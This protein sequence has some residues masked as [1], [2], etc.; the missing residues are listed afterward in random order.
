M[1]GRICQRDVDLAEADEPVR[2]AAERMH[3]RAVGSLV[4]VDEKQTPIGIVTDRDLTIRVLAA[5]RDADTTPVRDVMTSSP[6]TIRE[7]EPIE[8]AV[9]KM[10]QGTFRRIPVVDK[11]GVLVGLVSVDD[12]LGLLVEEFTDVG[13]LLECESPKALVTGRL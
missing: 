11:S 4:I 8:F 12:I 5:G 7:D 9:K 1:I 10:R 2:F 3:Q 6:V 13:A